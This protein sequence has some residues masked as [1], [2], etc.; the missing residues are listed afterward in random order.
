MTGTTHKAEADPAD[1]RSTRKGSGPRDRGGG[2]CVICVEGPCP[3]SEPQEEQA[4]SVRDMTGTGTC[5]KT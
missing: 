5:D 1:R 4:T 2:T 3:P